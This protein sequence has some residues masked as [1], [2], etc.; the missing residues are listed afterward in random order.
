MR[1]CPVSENRDACGSYASNFC[2]RS[3]KAM[4]CSMCF[5]SISTEALA[6]ALNEPASKIDFQQP[7]RNQRCFGK[8]FWGSEDRDASASCGTQCKPKQNGK[9]L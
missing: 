5:R 3:P 7:M 6:L 9:C 1:K 4:E 2:N 8:H